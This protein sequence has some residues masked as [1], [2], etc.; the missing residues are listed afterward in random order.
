[1]TCMTSLGLVK[2]DI[3]AK[4]TAAHRRISR[5]IRLDKS[6]AKNATEKFQVFGAIYKI[7]SDSDARGKVDGNRTVQLDLK[8]RDR[9][10]CPI[11]RAL[12]IDSHGRLR[13][14]FPQALQLYFNS[15][16]RYVFLTLNFHFINQKNLCSKMI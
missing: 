2:Q 8:K 12:S 14:H 16:D 13:H 11:R 1:M 4:L 6:S 7:L 15:E 5:R 9:F 10:A 3:D